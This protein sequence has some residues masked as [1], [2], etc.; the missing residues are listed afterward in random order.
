MEIRIRRGRR[1][2]YAALAALGDWP[3]VDGPAARSVRL[4]RRVVSDLAYD[5]YVA[6]AD[7][8]IVGLLAV[9]YVRV[10]P[11]GGQR[12]RLE[13]LVVGREHRGLGV[14]RKLVDLAL[15][16]ARKRGV[17]VIEARANDE[18]SGRFLDH[19]GFRVQ[20]RS[21]EISLPV[22]ASDA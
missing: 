12:A 10:L 7:E 8:R 16:R 18:G 9:S 19:V 14:G 15:R 20:G 6:E 21:Y 11:L 1:T 17:R 5:L 2:D 4:F 13:E 22:E 3:S